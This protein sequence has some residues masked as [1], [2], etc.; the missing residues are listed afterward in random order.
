MQ[1]QQQRDKFNSRLHDLQYSAQDLQ[2]LID[3]N[4]RDIEHGLRSNTSI[5]LNE[6]QQNFSDTTTF[7][8]ET[9]ER[10]NSRNPN[11]KI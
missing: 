2:S 7:Q 5:Q 4:S 9:D 8:Y 1:V 3:D 6:N 11:R 10:F